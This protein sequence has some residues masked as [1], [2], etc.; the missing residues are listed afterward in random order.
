MASNKIDQLQV[1]TKKLYIVE[2]I[3]RAEYLDQKKNR[4]KLYEEL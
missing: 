2:F 1:S 4:D 3:V